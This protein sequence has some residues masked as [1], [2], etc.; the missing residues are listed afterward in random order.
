MK[1]LLLLIALTGFIFSLQAQ[2]SGGPDN[3]GYIWRDSNDPNGQ[4][5]N[6]ID[7]RTDPATTIINGL[8]DDILLDLSHYRHLSP[9]TGIR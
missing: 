5:Y 4:A 1:K 7:I 6:W 9:I 8:G 2:T 3:Y